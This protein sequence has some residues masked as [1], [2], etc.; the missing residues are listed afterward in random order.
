MTKIRC[1]KCRGQKSYAG[2]GGIYKKCEKCSGTGTIESEVVI[3]PTVQIEETIEPIVKQKKSKQRK[4]E[5]ITEDLPFEEKEEV[6]QVLDVTVEKKPIF[7]GY[8]DELML[9]ILDEPRMQALD[10]AKKYAHVK[11]LFCISPI[12]GLQD[13]LIT[14]VQ[15]ASIRSMYG[16]RQTIA[17]RKVDLQRAQNEASKTDAEYAAFAMQERA[18]LEGE[19]REINE[20]MKSK[21]S[22]G[23]V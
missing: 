7:P 17:P 6:A 19:T 11:G 21:R 3:L 12:T 8:D 10:W 2:I 18:R 13:E 22:I 14:K 4:L 15:R 1:I 5:P 20:A 23:G 16:Q 9:A